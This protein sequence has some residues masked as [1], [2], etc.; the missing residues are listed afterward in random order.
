[1]PCASKRLHH[2]LAA[3]HP[4][5]VVASPRAVAEGHGTA[6]PRAATP[7]ARLV[8]RRPPFGNDGSTPCRL[9]MRMLSAVAAE[10]VRLPL[11]LPVRR[12]RGTAVAR[13]SAEALR[14]GSPRESSAA[15][16]GT[17]LGAVLIGLR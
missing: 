16:G 12:L 11:L 7:L 8:A 9:L 13:A 10:T 17:A 6:S 14:M 4:R 15:A 2:G 1:M 3:G 5:H